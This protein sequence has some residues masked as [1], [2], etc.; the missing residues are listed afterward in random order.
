MDNDPAGE[1]PVP[2][3]NSQLSILNYPFALEG[4][5]L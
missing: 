2:V 1:S 4:V 5:C 3:L